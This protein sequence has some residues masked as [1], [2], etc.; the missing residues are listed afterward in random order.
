[1]SVVD[2]LLP[3]VAHGLALLAAP[4]LV[5]GLVNRTRSRWSGRR[6]PPV[7]QLGFDLLRLLRK[8]AVYSVTA[9]WFVRGGPAVVLAAALLAGLIAPLAPGYAP[10]SFPYDFVLFAYLLGLGRLVLVL[11]ALDTGS[12]FEGM[13]ASRQATFAALVEPALFVAI[14]ALSSVAAGDRSLAHLLAFEGAGGAGG[15]DLLA[16]GLLFVALFVVLQAEAARVPIDDP[17]THLELTMIHEVMVLDHAGPDL[18]ALQY[19]AAIE[20]TTCAA[21]CAA[22]LNPFSAA[23]HPALAAGA[24]A[25]LVAAV[26]VLVGTV[27]SLVAR[28][29]LRVVPRYLLSALVAGAAALAVLLLAHGQGGLA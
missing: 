4:V 2:T 5:T 13:G 16:R 23:T 3:A 10:L 29:R 22:V 1:V 21:L 17:A 24:A 11:A 14:G 15:L 26:A 7:L 19:A 18:A 8:R 20:L 6:G 27:E 12:S 25:L 9:T 28:L